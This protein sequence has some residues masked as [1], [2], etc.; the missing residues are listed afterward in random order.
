MSADYYCL[1]CSR[2]VSLGDIPSHKIEH[3]DL[4]RYGI[5]WPSQEQVVDYHCRLIPTYESEVFSQVLGVSRVYIRDEGASFSGSMKDYSVRRALQLGLCVNKNAFYVVSSGNHACSLA[6][7][8]KI[9]DA[10][11][12]VFTLAD[13]SKMD[14]LLNLPNTLAIGVRASI[15]EEVYNFVSRAHLDDNCNLY[16][17]NV[18]N[19]RLLPAFTPIAEDI[20]QLD[21]LPTHIL[22]GV[23][24]GSY[25]AGIGLGFEWLG[26]SNSPKIVAVGMSGAFP[27]ETAHTQGKYLHEYKEFAVP[28]E[29]IDAAEGSIATE[30]YSMPQLMHAIRLTNGC[31]L[32]G[33]TNTDLR[34]A[35]CLLSLDKNLVAR[36]VIPE[37]TGIMSL[38]AA[39]KWRKGFTKNDV[40]LLSFTGHGAKDWRGIERLVSNMCNNLVNAAKTS[41]PDLINIKSSENHK[42]ALIVDRTT[43]P[44]AL[45]KLVVDYI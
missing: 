14:F 12:L 37:P 38:A 30:S 15:F 22:S 41:R 9:H 24:N 42:S 10:H 40:L 21:P 18:N 34:D 25:L 17:A 35:Y 23:G 45:R 16:N 2:S 39:L 3:G 43:S 4:A 8:A 11:A 19:E 28:E 1:I 13:C 26:I 32:G 29:E 36:G 20:K 27:S 33:L 31:T 6:M 5:M 44:E 7:H